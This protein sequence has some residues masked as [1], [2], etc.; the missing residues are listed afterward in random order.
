MGQEGVFS[1]IGVWHAGGVSEHP[2]DYR[3]LV[4]ELACRPTAWLEARRDQLVREQRRLRVE[5]LAV[6]AALDTRGALDDALAARDG[7][8][9]DPARQR[10]ETARAL[11]DLPAVAAAAH[12]GALSEEQLAPLAR[13]ADA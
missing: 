10:V 3:E 13:L 6:T 1:V 9:V 12:A 7:V 4:G 2:F 5:E 11:E 8:S